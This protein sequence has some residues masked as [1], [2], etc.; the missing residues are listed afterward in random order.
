LHTSS[1]IRLSSPLLVEAFLA[2]PIDEL[3]LVP[4]PLID[5]LKAEPAFAVLAVEALVCLPLTPIDT[6]PR[7]DNTFLNTAKHPHASPVIVTVV[8][9]GVDNCWSTEEITPSKPDL[10][11]LILGVAVTLVKLFA[12]VLALFTFSTNTSSLIDTAT[13]ATIPFNA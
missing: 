8:E 7:L 6:L 10:S 2:P 12:A 1:F 3:A 13:I 4:P 5:V 11:P 9:R